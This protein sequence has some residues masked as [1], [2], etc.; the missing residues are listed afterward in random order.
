MDTE[1]S[2]PE[3][4]GCRVFN[5]EVM[6]KR[7]P[8]NVYESIAHTI[9]KPIAFVCNGQEYDDIIKFNTEWM[10]DRMFNDD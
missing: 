4:F 9:G 2:I 7:L 6:R 8:Q 10:I 5:D 3:L 1:M